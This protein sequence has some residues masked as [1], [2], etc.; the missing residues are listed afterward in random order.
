[1]SF[2][3]RVVYRSLRICIAPSNA[4]NASPSEPSA[5]YTLALPDIGM[6]IYGGNVKA[7]GTGVGLEGGK[8]LCL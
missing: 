1:M 3:K 7:A 5:F 8:D 6:E 4:C 2:E